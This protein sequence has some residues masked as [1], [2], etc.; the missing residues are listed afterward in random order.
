MA[1]HSKRQGRVSKAKIHVSPSC[2]DSI[3]P[4]SESHWKISDMTIIAEGTFTD[5][6]VHSTTS[7]LPC[8]KDRSPSCSSVA[9]S[10]N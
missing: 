3:C 7:G 1:L 5:E 9:D 2:S 6:D 10:H 8:P 4:P